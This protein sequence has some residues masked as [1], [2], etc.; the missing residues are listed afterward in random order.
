MR[1]KTRGFSMIEVLCGIFLAAACATILAA[2]L[3]VAGKSRNRADLN[4]KATSYAQ[5]QLER[6]RGE[7]Y[8]SLTATLLLGDGLIDSATP[9]SGTTYS[10][11]N[12]GSAQ[13]QSVAQNLPG[14]T[15]SVTIE[16]ADTD[17]RRIRVTVTY[18]VDG[19]TRTINLGT[20]VANL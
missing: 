8:A 19:Q 15:G 20:L 10:F 3:P 14:G 6:V 4:N 16:Q 17:L 5:R 18:A 7:G 11:T 9:T 12:V 13:N 2:T 1:K